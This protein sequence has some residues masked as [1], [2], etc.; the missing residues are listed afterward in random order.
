M[1]P[2]HRGWNRRRLAAAGALVL[3]ITAACTSGGGDASPGDTTSA[4]PSTTAS[5]VTVGAGPTRRW[6][7]EEALVADPD[8][9]DPVDGAPVRIGFAADLGNFGPES[10]GPEVEAALH[11]ISLI[12]CSG[13]V[14]G[15]SVEL[16]VVDISGSPRVTQLAVRELIDTGVSAI[17]GPPAADP[18]LR[19]LQETA[20]SIPVVFA[21]STEPALADASQL[22]FL[23]AFDDTRAATAAAEFALDQGWRT[24]VTFSSPGPYFGYN[25]QVFTEVFQAGGGSVIAD[26]GH[27]PGETIGF[28][29]E[30][31]EIAAGAPDVIYAPMFAD[32]ISALRRELDAAEVTGE[33]I[34]GDSFEATGGYFTDGVDGIYH[35]THAFA[36]PGNRVAL[37]QESFQSV[38]GDSTENPNFAALF[39]DALTVILDA[40]LR[41][42]DGSPPAIG[43][44]IAAGADIEGVTGTL[45]YD[46][47]AIPAKPV[48]IHL[49]ADGEPTLAAVIGP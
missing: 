23:A 21:A 48:Y 44:A 15:Q 17:I 41:S 16:Q 8:C 6:S 27:V 39:G 47:G 1:A 20:G 28:S 18:G 24:A 25:P 5:P 12:N 37:L 22:S 34:A 29:S 46:G 19:I 43:A 4:Q 36:E 13:G 40:Y 45:S 11:L 26:F 33:I 14:A 2:S 7:I 42:G 3:I 35:T 30:V 32:Q 31:A 10:D 49:V 9:Q 38:A